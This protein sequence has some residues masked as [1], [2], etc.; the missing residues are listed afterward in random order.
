[1]RPSMAIVLLVGLLIDGCAVNPGNPYSLDV[2]RE[3]LRKAQ[4]NQ[5]RT[6]QLQT[7]TSWLTWVEQGDMRYAAEDECLAVA[8]GNQRCREPSNSWSGAIPGGS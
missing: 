6:W 7:K 8:I 1:V 5:G 4:L 3:Q 2:W